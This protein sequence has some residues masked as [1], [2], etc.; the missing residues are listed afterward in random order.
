M[1]IM[2]EYKMKFVSSLTKVFPMEEPEDDLGG[3][4]LTGL[5]EENTSLQCAYYGNEDGLD[6]LEVKAEGELAPYVRI[7]TVRLMPSVYACAPDTDGNYLRRDAGMYPDCLTVPEN[8]MVPIVR[9]Q[10]QSL[11]L[12]IEKPGRE[13]AGLRSLVLSF[14]KE[15]KEVWRGEA[16][17]R[18]YDCSVVKDGIYH[19]EWFHADCIADYYKTPV[20]SDRHWELLENFI[21]VYAKRE[22]NTILVPIFTPPLDTAVGRE[23]TTVQLLDIDK[24]EDGTYLF[25]YERVERFIS[26][27]QKYG[28]T[29]FEMAHLFT[30]WGA[31]SAPKI[32]A[33]LPDGNEKRIFGWE[34]RADDEN[35]LAFL[36]QLLTGLRT[37]LDEWDLSGHVFFHLSDEPEEKDI[38]AYARARKF[39]EGLL[40]DYP[41]LDAVSRYSFYERGIVNKPV[42]GTDHVEP[43]LEHGVE[44][45]WTYY[46]G[47][48][49][50]EVSNRFFSM[51]SARTAILGVQLYRMGMEGFLHWGFNF[52]N[53][54][55]SLKHINPYE[56]TD[57]GGAFPSGD[58][59]LVY[60]GKDGIPEES[61]RLVL[62]S[63][64]MQDIRLLKTLEALTDKAYVDD[65][66]DREAKGPVNFKQY[67]KG[68]G[69]LLRLR[70]LV[71]EQITNRQ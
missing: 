41:V 27:C 52:Y 36:A 62:L 20:W 44:G 38:E 54:Q 39:T 47:C 3:T 15:G 21:A 45:L 59:F 7:R 66:I 48:Q 13:L 58:A 61:L 50:T 43:F 57:A 55:Y 69:Y 11:W 42:P 65:L 40:G 29:N 70:R 5:C 51:P 67:P 10:W 28:I 2:A 1:G 23:R 30:Q 9:Q 31:T 16:A 64:A 19:T 12:E 68:N 6:W 46:C 71:A 17:V 33:K 8:G 35:Y 37:K 24:K 56:V 53:T 63:G 34:T 26:L 22:I 32:M 18:L 14:E 49:G 4:V 25:H 60:P